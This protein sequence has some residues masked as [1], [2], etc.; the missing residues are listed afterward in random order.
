MKGRAVHYAFGRRYD[1]GNFLSA[2]QRATNTSVFAFG[3]SGPP[4]LNIIYL[5]FIFIWQVSPVASSR[6][7]RIRPRR[8]V[9]ERLAQA[10]CRWRLG[11]RVLVR[12]KDDSELTKSVCMGRPLDVDWKPGTVV[13]V[14]PLKVRLKGG[15]E[16]YSW[17]SIKARSS[18]Q[19]SLPRAAPAS[20][21]VL[22]RARKLSQRRRKREEVA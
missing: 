21:E 13:S 11:D 10:N 1:F 5:C 2:G 18:S 22:K 4:C 12:D 20:V 14:A 15:Q 8:S 6:P 19:S 9:F 3:F 16:A 17:A 7:R